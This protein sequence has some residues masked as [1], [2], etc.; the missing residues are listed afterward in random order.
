[1]IEAVSAS[2]Q[3]GI[4]RSSL[5][6]WPPLVIGLVAAA[7][8][9]F[10]SLG[11][12]A[13]TVQVIGTLAFVTSSRLFGSRNWPVF[14]FVGLTTV[15]VMIVIGLTRAGPFT[16]SDGVHNRL[17]LHGR[18]FTAKSIRHLDFR[19]AL[20]QGA[21]FH[22]LDL[23]GKNFNGAN[24]SGADLS[25]TRL[26][27]AEMRGVDMRGANFSWSCLRAVNL[28]GADLHGANMTSTDTAGATLPEHAKTIAFGWPTKKT[29]S[30]PCT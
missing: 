2:K 25:R 10:G 14:G 19:G 24:L 12:I 26:D 23:R 21:N 15:T 16:P 29:A 5:W 3:P 28:T 6:L 13:V 9:F 11:A 30:S 7:G 17:D 22:G 8:Q 4:P 20:L 27:G 1:M 18:T